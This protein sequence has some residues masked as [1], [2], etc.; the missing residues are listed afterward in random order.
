MKKGHLTVLYIFPPLIDFFSCFL[1]LIGLNNDGN[2]LGNKQKSGKRG[3]KHP[4]VT[5]KA[6]AM[7]GRGTS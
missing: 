2:R 1:E 4:V 7:E 5:T 6:T 3:Y